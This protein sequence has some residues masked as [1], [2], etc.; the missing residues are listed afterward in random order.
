MANIAAIAQRYA[1]LEHSGLR[2]EHHFNAPLHFIDAINV[3]PLHTAVGILPKGKINRRERHPVVRN[4]KVVL[5]S[6][7]LPC[8]AISDVGLL[9]PGI[10]LKPRLAVDLVNACIRNMMSARSGSTLHL[11]I[12]RREKQLAS[13]GGRRDRSDWSEACKGN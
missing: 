8:P 10:H 5:D 3:P 13:C 4:R 11:D 1:L 7:S 9:Y 2:M 12:G 6:K